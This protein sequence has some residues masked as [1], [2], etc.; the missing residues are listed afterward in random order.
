MSL[1]VP[2][3]LKPQKGL[4]H[5]GKNF[6]IRDGFFISGWL[7]NA[8]AFVLVLTKLMQSIKASD[9]EIP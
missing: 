2:G 4:H 8:L 1:Y 5:F 9:D 6:K 7:K 3:G